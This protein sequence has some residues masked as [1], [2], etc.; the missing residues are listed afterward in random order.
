MNRNLL[1]AALVLAG[2]ILTGCGG[3]AYVAGIDATAATLLWYY[4]TGPS[5]GTQANIAE[6]QFPII[7]FPAAT[8]SY[9]VAF[10]LSD[11]GMTILGR[12]GS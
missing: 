7:Q 8:K 6:G 12:A 11:A 10:S 2:T 3:G 5:G 4:K 1:T 9:G